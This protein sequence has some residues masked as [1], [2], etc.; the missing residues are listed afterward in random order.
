MR[1][2]A[3]P[4]DLTKVRTVIYHLPDGQTVAVKLEGLQEFM[5]LRHGNICDTSDVNGVV[6]FFFFFYA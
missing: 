4:I 5:D 2:W 1:T 6:H 3:K